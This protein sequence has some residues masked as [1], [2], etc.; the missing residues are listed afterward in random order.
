MISETNLYEK[1]NEQLC[2]IILTIAAGYREQ[3]CRVNIFINFMNTNTEDCNVMHYID[4]GH[5][6]MTWQ[7][8]IILTPLHDIFHCTILLL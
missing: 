2:P 8:D 3:K 5:G 1:T 4:T 6:S 7:F